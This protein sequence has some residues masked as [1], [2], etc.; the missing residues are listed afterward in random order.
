MVE[1]NKKKEEYNLDYFYESFD[2]ADV[3][4]CYISMMFEIDE[5]IEIREMEQNHYNGTF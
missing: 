3:D 5:E 4:D 1:V 2:K